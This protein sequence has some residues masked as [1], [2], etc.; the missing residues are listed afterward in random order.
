[1]H[2]SETGRH[3]F[4]YTNS[5]ITQCCGGIILDTFLGGLVQV[6]YISKW[7]AYHANA[8]LYDPILNLANACT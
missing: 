8:V 6:R 7:S 3:I 1:M 5:S 2:D 4:L